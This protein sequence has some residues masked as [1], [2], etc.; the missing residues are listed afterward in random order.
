VQAVHDGGLEPKFPFVTDEA[1]FRLCG[2]ISAQNSKHWSSI[3]LREILEVPIHNQKIGMW[4]AITAMQIAGPT[5]FFNILLIQSGM[6][7]TFFAPC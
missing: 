4:H 6:S 2:Y 3:N 5:V 1:C 7:V